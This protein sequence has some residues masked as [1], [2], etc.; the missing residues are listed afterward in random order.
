MSTAS[1]LGYSSTATTKSSGGLGSKYV[2]PE[3]DRFCSAVKGLCGLLRKK[4]SF[5]ARNLFNASMCIC[6]PHHLRVRRL[7]HNDLQYTEAMP[8]PDSFPAGRVDLLLAYDWPSDAPF[9]DVLGACFSGTGLRSAARSPR[10]LLRSLA[11]VPTG[12]LTS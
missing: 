4:S 6:P 1:P 9:L 2:R 12:Q 8:L 10:L 7:S 11:A 5:S 3:N